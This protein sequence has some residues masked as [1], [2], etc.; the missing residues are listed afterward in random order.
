MYIP[1]IQGVPHGL[2]GLYR[3]A[4][5]AVNLVSGVGHFPFM[6]MLG[7][8]LLIAQSLDLAR[9]LSYWLK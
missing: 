5:M 3:W 6:D 7:K 2:G 9:S 8:Y 1:C 4:T